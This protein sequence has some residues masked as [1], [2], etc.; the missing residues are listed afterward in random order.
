LTLG[1]DE[2]A[3]FLVAKIAVFAPYRGPAHCGS[4]L[5]H[6]VAVSFRRARPVNPFSANTPH[7][8]HGTQNDF[9]HK[10]LLWLHLADAEIPFL[11]DPNGISG[12][13]R[14]ERECLEI[15]FQDTPSP[16]RL[17]DAGIPYSESGEFAIVRS[18]YGRPRSD[19]LQ[20]FEMGSRY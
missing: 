4:Q 2:P 13:C 9:A 20:P 12:S 6:R 11:N 10:C 14:A 18:G 19:S 17:I 3:V 1:S 8:T 16:T 5:I 15:S 7:F